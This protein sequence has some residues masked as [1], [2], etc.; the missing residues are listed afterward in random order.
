MF[1]RCSGQR[2]NFQMPSMFCSSNVP[3][4]EAERLSSCL[5]IPLR[6][7]IGRYLGHTIVQDGK[8]RERHMELLQWV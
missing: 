7:K 3:S 2:V 5:G 1:C 6:E 8:N 4:H